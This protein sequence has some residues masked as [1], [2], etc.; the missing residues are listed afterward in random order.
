[1]RLRYFKTYRQWRLDGEDNYGDKV[2]F[3]FFGAPDATLRDLGRWVEDRLSE[4]DTLSGVV[5]VY[6]SRDALAGHIRL[7]SGRFVECEALG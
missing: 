6:R 5:A 1:M 2:A 7:A 3:E 4:H